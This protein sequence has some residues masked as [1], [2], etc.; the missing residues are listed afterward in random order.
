MQQVMGGQR[1]LPSWSGGDDLSRTPPGN[2]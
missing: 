1:N 2:S